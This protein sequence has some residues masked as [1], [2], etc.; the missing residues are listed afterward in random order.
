MLDILEKVIISFYF[1]GNP[2][3]GDKIW[4]GREG[5]FDALATYIHECCHAFGGDSSQAFS[6]G[7]TQAME[8]LM[9]HFSVVEEYK[10]KW[11]DIFELKN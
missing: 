3:L 2:L 10:K 8:L 4:E 5:Y 6:L 1:I 9:T 11:E 7:L